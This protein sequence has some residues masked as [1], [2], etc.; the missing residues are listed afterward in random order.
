MV[1]MIIMIV[2]ISINRKEEIMRKKV[3]DPVQ[4]TTRFKIGHASLFM[5]PIAR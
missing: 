1:I 2:M 3:Y 4:N 5:L